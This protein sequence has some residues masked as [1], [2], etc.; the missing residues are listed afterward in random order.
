M[1]SG[2]MDNVY[3]ILGYVLA[4]LKPNEI[5]E[6]NSFLAYHGRDRIHG[7]RFGVSAIVRNNHGELASAFFK[8]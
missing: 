5:L 6:L 1:A 7:S 2:I 4:N 3:P 8:P